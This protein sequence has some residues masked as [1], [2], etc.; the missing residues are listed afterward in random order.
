MVVLLT[1]LSSCAAPAP[2]Q[3]ETTTQTMTPT[4]STFT[5]TPF[6]TI[7]PPSSYMLL[8]AMNEMEQLPPK[9]SEPETVFTWEDPLTK[10]TNVAVG[11]ENKVFF[12][13]DFD[14]GF[15]CYQTTSQIL[16]QLL[17]HHFPFYLNDGTV[18]WSPSRTKA[19][20]WQKSLTRNRWP[21]DSYLIDFSADAITKC[22]T[23]TRF[24]GWRPL[25]ESPL[26]WNR[27][28]YGARI[29]TTA[30][31]T[32]WQSIDVSPSCPVK[33]PDG[34]YSNSIVTPKGFFFIPEDDTTWCFDF[35][36]SLFC[37]FQYSVLS[38]FE[39]CLLYL[40]G[41]NLMG[42]DK[43]TDRPV[44]KIWPQYL[45]LL[46]DQRSRLLFAWEDTDISMEFRMLGWIS[47][48][49]FVCTLGNQISIEDIYSAS[50]K[51][52]GALL[53]KLGSVF[54][55]PFLNNMTLGYDYALW[56][57][58]EHNVFRIKLPFLY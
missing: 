45:Y 12:Y 5:P 55:V 46:S 19:I 15:Y 25:D 54:D 42:F 18:K 34:D 11:P 8:N 3:E 41:G 20:V 38:G 49:F 24:I 37:R 40:E 27:I 39:D 33:I 52:I 2:I 53:K 22:P 14:G 6:Q 57:Y 30:S 48:D 35:S 17:T 56:G 9:L 58:D 51:P 50:I 44:I 23:E 7:R 43:T 4:Q 36:S 32:I 31:A 13:N 1:S 16:K 29:I 28:G 47:M 26:F 21:L 10:I